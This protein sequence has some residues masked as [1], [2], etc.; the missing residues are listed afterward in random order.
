M[1]K[2]LLRITFFALLSGLTLVLAEVAGRIYLKAEFQTDFNN[3]DSILWKYYYTIRVIRQE[4]DAAPKD[5]FSV[6]LLGGSV[7]YHKN[8]QVEEELERQLNLKLGEGNYRIYNAAVPGHSSMDSYLKSQLLQ[9][10]H[11]DL[12]IFYHGIN[13][14]RANNC[15][16]ELFK[17]DYSHYAWYEETQCAVGNLNNAPVSVLPFLMGRIK[18]RSNQTRH[19]DDYVPRDHPKEEWLAEGSQLKTPKVFR[20]NLNHIVDFASRTGAQLLVPSFAYYLDPQYNKEDY[21]ARKLSYNPKAKSQFAVETWG[22]PSNVV[23]GIDA[24]NSVIDELWESQDFEFFDMDG[25]LPK[26]GIYF[27]D[28]CHLS[29]SGSV[30][31]IELL[32]P[33]ILETYQ[34]SRER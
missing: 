22:L 14:V 1:R 20:T 8:G 25:A 23:A 32:M 17:E 15:P 11:F 4:R 7:L 6:L 5:Q 16:T 13:E 18:V 33:Q 34:A 30:K 28:I 24:H 10:R 12:I 27:D 3:F 29:D 21:L 9:D 19:P 31:F 2:A 26:S